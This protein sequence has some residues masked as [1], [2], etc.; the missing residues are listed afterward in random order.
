MDDFDPTLAGTA[1]GIEAQFD[2]RWGVWLSDTGQWWAA[3]TQALTAS[4]LA[5][6]CVPYLQASSPGDLRERIKDEEAL[7]SPRK[8]HKERQQEPEETDS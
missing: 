5:A 6:G 4:E 3:R 7:A 8:P 2:G 1:A